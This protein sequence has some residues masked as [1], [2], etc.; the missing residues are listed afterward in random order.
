MS[1]IS[2]LQPSSLWQFFAKI[3]SIPHPSYHEQAIAEWIMK[4]AEE[5]Q[6]E[7]SRDEAGN[8]I[9]RKP[10]TPGMEDCKGAILQAH[11]DMVPQANSDSQHDFTRD[12]IEAY[13]DGEWVTAKGT[14]L[15]SD[16]GIGLAS[17]LAVF[18]ANN[19]AHGPLEALLTMTE[20]AGMEGAFGLKPG[21][22]KGSVLINTDSEQEGDVYMGCAGGIDAYVEFDANPIPAPEGVALTIELKGLKGGHSGCDIHTGRGNAN[23]LLTRLLLEFRQ[24]TPL[25]LVSLNGGNLRNAIPR[26]AHATIIIAPGSE[27][28]L[29]QFID[30][31]R[32][33]LNE[34]IGA[35][36]ANLTLSV[37]PA[38][39]PQQAM[40]EPLTHRLLHALNVCPNGVVSMSQEITGVVETSL[41]LGIVHT[42]DEGQVNM[43]MLVRSLSD[44]HRM[45]VV[46]VLTS[47]FKLAD[48]KLHT[49]GGYPGWKP[50]PD[51]PI[52][53]ITQA[54]YEE[55]YG[56]K[57]HAMV[58]HAGLECALFKTAYPHWDM[59]SFG[60]TIRFPH[61]PDE[62]VNIK[63]V[64]KYWLLLV[65]TL[66]N[67]P[68]Q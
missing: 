43:Q 30:E 26:E 51:S 4:W 35:V 36:E 15:G 38:K 22:F 28:K 61:S 63:S 44:S 50:D 64:E 48:A 42:T 53:K 60:P 34:E 18:D 49:E 46:E 5:K 33:T 67:I 24:S 66:K 25:T 10:A 58:I 65:A 27:A 17:I 3:C 45:H 9:L 13:I 39:K 62:K 68:K 32:A 41:N 47:L 12:P 21:L 2:E 20:E 19:I 56:T 23:K 11:L 7:A 57:P 31:F 14:T 1:S 54:T 59:V 55:L 16:N 8:I 6:I 52:M 29:Q 40:S 37:T